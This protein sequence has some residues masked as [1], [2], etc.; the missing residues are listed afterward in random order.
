MPAALIEVRRQYTEAEEVAII[1]AVHAAL[2]VAFR[3]PPEDRNVRL[4]AHAPH[5]FACSPDVTQPEYRTLVTIDCFSGRSVDAKR[6]LY[7]AIVER[8]EPLGI[9]RD[10]VSTIVHDIPRE[11]WGLSG[12]LAASDVDLGFEVN[13]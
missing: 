6:A 12:G 10:H 4:I 1:D 8:L 11:S 7:A 9:P 5:R 3:I 2:V 13:V